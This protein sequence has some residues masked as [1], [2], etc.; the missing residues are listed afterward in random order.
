MNLQRKKDNMRLHPFL[1]TS[2]LILTACAAPAKDLPAASQTESPIETE[3]TI[4]PAEPTTPVSGTFETSLLT[5]E[6]KGRSEGNLLFPLD[7]ATGTALPDYS[8][9]SLGQ[10]YSYAF[11]PDHR[12]LAAL[13]F[14]NDQA[15]NG[16]LLLIDLATWKSRPLELKPNGWA[17]AIVFSP[18]GK[19]LA[20][21]DGLSTYRLTIFDLEKESIIAQKEEN[22]LITRLKFTADSQSLMLYGMVVDNRFTENEMSGGAPQVKLLDASNLSPLWSVELK[23]VRDGIYPKDEKGP[24]DYSQPGTAIYFYPAVVFAPDQNTLYVVHADSEQLTIADF[25]LQKVEA[26]DIQPELSWFERLLS[27]TAGVAHAKVADGTSKQA[28]ISPDG[29][30]LY[31]VGMRSE[32]IQNKNGNWDMN[33]IPLGLEIIRISDGSR[34]EHLETDSADLSLSPDGRFLYLRNWTNTAPWT[35][36]FDTSKHQITSHQDEIYAM[37]VLRM[38]GEFLLVSTYSVS[39]TSH[40]MSIF[41][42]DGLKMLSQWTSKN[43]FAWLTP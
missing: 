21:A 35:E 36:T 14:L 24:V 25:D 29:Q 39:D 43:Y 23:D 19:R 31:V 10:S 5:V 7:P 17:S 38:N 4:V 1:L 3:P 13:T 8:P 9:I 42:P 33:Q 18:D 27:L 41:E 34:V 2:I 16:N 28:A 20:I 12:T 32:S 15:T 40:H 37:P 22:F 26:V 11:S 30:L 6:W